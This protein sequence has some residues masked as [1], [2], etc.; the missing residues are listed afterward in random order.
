MMTNLS[1]KCK[2]TNNNTFESEFWTISELGQVLNVG[3]V[4]LKKLLA[5]GKIAGAIQMGKQWRIHKETFY[6]QV[7]EGNNYGK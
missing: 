3:Q 6:K 4:T 1:N 2:E 7:K 5:E